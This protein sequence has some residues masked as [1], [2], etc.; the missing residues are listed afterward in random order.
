MA[1]LATSP[2]FEPI[3][4]FSIFAGNMIGRLNEIVQV[5]ASNEVHIMALSTQDITESTILRLIVD[6]PESAR[7]LF[8]DHGYSF[9]E[10]HV[11]AVEIKTEQQM[12]WVTAALTEAEININYVYAFLMRPEGRC[13]LAI[14]LEDNDVARQ[15][16]SAHGIKVL[17]QHD[18]A[19]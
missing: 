6:Y 7:R 15:V 10:H 13:G 2:R 19:R 1:D 18:I 11:V 8:E 4:Q 5:L 14:S 16:L 12:R 3:V 17:S 9:C